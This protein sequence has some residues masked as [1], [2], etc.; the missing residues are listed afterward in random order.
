MEF[1]VAPALVGGA[2]STTSLHMSR[3]L[4]GPG[5]ACRAKL[6]IAATSYEDRSDAFLDAT[7]PTS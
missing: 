6:L 2:I 3:A 7:P 5:H 4:H 1:C